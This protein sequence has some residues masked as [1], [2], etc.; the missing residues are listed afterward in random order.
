[1]RFNFA[2][3]GLLLAGLTAPVLAAESPLYIG[4]K[5]G[6]LEADFAGFGKATNLGVMLGY[7]LHHDQ[8]GTFAIETEFT[9]T[10]SDG[11]VAGG[12]AWDAD[13]IAATAAYR[14]AGSAY[15]K[16]KIGILRQDLNRSGGTLNAADSGIAYGAGVGARV[17][18]KVMLEVEYTRL[19]RDLS[20]LSLAY[21]THF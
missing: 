7:D 8:N 16:A 12:G 5:I 11:S 6:T 21:I 17:N 1:M 10:I 15:V 4:L 3:A 2:L 20:F 19:S 9:T 13:T 18:R 14:T